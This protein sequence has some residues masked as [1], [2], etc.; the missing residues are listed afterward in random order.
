MTATILRQLTDLGLVDP[1][2]EG[3]QVERPY[4]WVSNGNGSRVLS[5]KTGIRSVP[6]YEVSSTALAAW[7][8]R[9]GAE[10]WWN[11]DGDP[12]LTGRL[13]FPCPADELA[14]DLRKIDRPLLVQARMGDAAATGRSIGADEI[15][16]VVGNLAD[17]IHLIRSG[18]APPWGGDRLFYLCWKG[19]PHEWMLT[20]DSET[21][22]QM[23]GDDRATARE[24][25]RVE[26]E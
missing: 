22:E 13:T 17:S 19:S 6:H 9:Q 20:E 2:Y 26:K 7:L 24:T 16:D 4:L 21:S 3:D 10:R 12:L 18:Q 1:G 14:A 25:V 8:E 5:Y 11:V 15:D 23:R